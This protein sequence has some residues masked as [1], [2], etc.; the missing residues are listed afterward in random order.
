MRGSVKV[1]EGVKSLTSSSADEKCLLLAVGL[2]STRLGACHVTS[3]K[4]REDESTLKT[5]SHTMIVGQKLAHSRKVIARQFARSEAG[6]CEIMN[7]RV[8]SVSVEAVGEKKYM[9]KKQRV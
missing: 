6:L 5:C 2:S 1:C 8:R 3:A 7:Q 4:N 9:V